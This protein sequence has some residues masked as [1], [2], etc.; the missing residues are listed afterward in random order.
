[1]VTRN[2][3]SSTPYEQLRAGG[4][5]Y[6]CLSVAV[7]P[8][9]ASTRDNRPLSQLRVGVKDCYFLQGLKSS[10][11]NQ[12]YYDFSDPAPFTA[13]AV[14]VLVK[15][16]AVVLGQNKLSAMIGREEPLEA[17]DFHI[18][19]NPR[20]D[21]YQS[22]AG[23]SNGSAACV[24]T[25][26]WIDCAIGTDS[27]G[28]GRRPAMVN[29][30]WQFRPSH[31]W[32]SLSGMIQTY[33]RFDTPVVFAR[34]LSIIKPVAEAWLPKSI[35]E[36]PSTK[37]YHII[38]PLDY[39]P[40]E[41]TDQ[42]QLIDKFVEDM[43]AA[44]PA[45]V[46]KFSIREAWKLSRPPGTPEDVDN[47]LANTL[48]GT[49][50]YAHYHL[51]AAFRKGYA[52]KHDGKPPYVPPYLQDRWGK[53]AAVSEQQHKDS[54]QRIDIYKQW[55]LSTMF[56]GSGTEVETLVVL[57]IANAAPN[58]RDEISPSPRQQSAVDQLFLPSILGAPDMAIPI[59]EVPYASKITDRTEY[60]PVVVDIMGAP[61]KDW[62]LFQAVE[63]TMEFSGRP[64]SVTTGSRIFQHS[65]HK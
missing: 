40:V 62:E 51:F 11:C 6:D 31:R 5:F 55:L 48:E 33:A 45:K 26:D 57:P 56:G 10:L 36:T 47:Y 64:T 9:P 17:V 53:G 43:R 24:A 19:F 37:Q 46:T 60:L 25:Y 34:S 18:S 29:G 58:Y 3:S 35:D 30:V 49:Y 63:R 44:L 16:G 32:M 14:Q 23:S 15:Q 38:Y 21:G 20:G 8:R 54:E 13:E 50:Y 28:S 12:A 2:R 52:E 22:P 7:P 65:R 41:N 59:G 39:L 27:S 4:T 61:L 42:M 1:M